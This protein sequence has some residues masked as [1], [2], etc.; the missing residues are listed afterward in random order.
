V[1]VF[2]QCSRCQ[3]VFRRLERLRRNRGVSADPG[4]QPGEGGFSATLEAVP[5]DAVVTP[6]TWSYGGDEDWDRLDDGAGGTVG[7]AGQQQREITMS[8]YPSLPFFGRAKP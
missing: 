2:A 6:I 1:V 5:A 4:R 8:P 7:D 3:Q